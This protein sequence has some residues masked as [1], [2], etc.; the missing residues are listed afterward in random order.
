MMSH[1]LDTP[2][3]LTRM[4]F[5]FGIGGDD[6]ERRRDGPS[7]PAPPPASRKFAG[8]MPVELDNVHGRHRQASAIDHAADRAVE[9][10]VIEIVF[11]RLDFLGILFGLIRAAPRP[12]DDGTSRCRRT[13]LWRRAH[14]T[15]LLGDDERIDLKHCHV[16]MATKAA[17]QLADQFLRLLGEI[18]AETSAFA[19]CGRD[20]PLIPVAGS[21]EKVTRFFR[22]VV[23]NVLVLT[24]PSV[25]TTSRDFGGLPGRLGSKR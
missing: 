13:T 16:A 23:R 2:K 22:R 8:S 25:E 10:D 21:T 24:P 12:R 15:G 6:L 14:A 9:R 5:T 3:M 19:A 20:G 18:A 7:P 4:P 11:R 1:F 17:R